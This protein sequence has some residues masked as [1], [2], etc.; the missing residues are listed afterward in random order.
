VLFVLTGSSCAGKTTAAR[1]CA[2][3]PTLVVHDFD[4]LGVPADADLVWRQRRLQD[5]IESALDYQPRGLDML[6]TGQRRSA[7]CWPARLRPSWTASPPA[8]S[9]STM[10][11]GCGA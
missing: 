8:C 4:E 3:V 7:R 11:S 1:A 5:W 6:L 10:R 2:S 9:T